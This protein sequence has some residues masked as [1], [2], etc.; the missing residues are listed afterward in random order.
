MSD[1]AKGGRGPVS[2]PRRIR[3]RIVRG[4]LRFGRWMGDQVARVVFTVVYFTV[5]LPFGVGVSVRSDVL[6]RKAPPAWLPKRQSVETLE[7][8]RRSF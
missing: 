7:A 1:T 3:Q 4:W 6:R 2:T 5:V 8:T